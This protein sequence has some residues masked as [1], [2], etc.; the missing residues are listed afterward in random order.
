MNCSRSG[1]ASEYLD[2]LYEWY[3]GFDVQQTTVGVDPDEFAVIG[4][5]P[6]GVAVRVKIE[7]DGGV[8]AV[9]DGDDWTLPGGIVATEP[10]HGTIAAVAERWTGIECEIDGLDCVSLVCLQCESANETLWTI[11]A[12]FSATA[13]GGTPKNGAVWRDR[14][15]P[16]AVPA[17]L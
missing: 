11:S 9:P 17:A 16:I 3:D 6:E 15:A 7:G 10:T 14:S 2:A 12:Q 4:D 1:G 8:V 5:R 13:I